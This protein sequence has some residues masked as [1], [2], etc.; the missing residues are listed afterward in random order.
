M[1]KTAN[2][3]DETKFNEGDVI[4][5]L[6]Q[7]GERQAWR[8]VAGQF[9]GEYA[10]QYQFSGT[11]SRSISGAIAESDGS[12][13]RYFTGNDDMSHRRYF[14]GIRNAKSAMKR[15]YDRNN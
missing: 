1:T 4:A 14:T 6:T 15:H 3:I 12:T 10:L 8:V 9:V 11:T 5:T 13:W 2:Q 7:P